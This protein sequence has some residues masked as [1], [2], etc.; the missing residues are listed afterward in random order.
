MFHFPLAQFSVEN[1]ARFLQRKPACCSAKETSPS[2]GVCFTEFCLGNFVLPCCRQHIA[3]NFERRKI[4][5]VFCLFVVASG[6]EQPDTKPTFSVCFVVV[7]GGSFCLFGSHLNQRPK[8]QCVVVNCCVCYKQNLL[9]VLS[10]VVSFVLQVCVGFNEEGR[11]ISQLLCVLCY[12]LVMSLT[13]RAASTH[14]CC[15]RNF[16]WMPVL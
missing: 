3:C 2:I 12:R 13:G 16:T 5:L 9:T 15:V 11:I 8:G 7:L 1:L 4:I 10:S 14:A 6:L